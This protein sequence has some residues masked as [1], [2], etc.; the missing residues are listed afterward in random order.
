M[1]TGSH[2]AVPLEALLAESAWLRRLATS[3]VRD[4][5]A[6]EDLVQETWLA[7]LKNPPTADRPLR[8]WLRTV[9]ENFVRMRARGEQ[10]RTTRERREAREEATQGEVEL[11]ERVEEQ[12]FLAREVLKLEEPF[13]STLV[14]RYYEGL[15]SIQ[16]AERVGSNDNTVR[17]R[18]KRGLELLRERLDRRHGGDRGAWLALLSPL[19]PRDFAPVTAP[20]AS[21]GSGVGLWFAGAAAMLAL[22]AGVWFAV[23]EPEHEEQLAALANA[24][25]PAEQP[26]NDGSRA[27]VERNEPASAP[28]PTVLAP[29]R[30]RA[31]VLDVQ[32]EPVSGARGLLELGEAEGPRG[33]SRADGVLEFE[34]SGDSVLASSDV[35]ELSATG[36]EP[37]RVYAPVRPGETLELG[38]LVL[39]RTG[40][41]LGSVRDASG[42]PI[43]AAEVRL[44]RLGERFGALR[45]PPLTEI[46]L[47]GAGLEVSAPVVVESDVDGRFRLQDVAEAYYR[48][49]IRAE[50]FARQCSGPLGV[51]QGATLMLEPFV[52]APP[53]P[54]RLVRGVVLDAHGAPV[55]QARVVG[56]RSS[57]S[58]EFNW[59]EGDVRTTSDAQGRFTLAA[60]PGNHYTIAATDG[61]RFASA[62]TLVGDR[63]ELLLRLQERPSLELAIGSAPIGELEILGVKD[64]ADGPPLTWQV[65]EGVIGVRVEVTREFTL[66]VKHGPFQFE[67]RQ[68]ALDSRD[69]VLPERIDLG[70]PVVKALEVRVVAQGELV[71]G[72]HVELGVSRKGSGWISPAANATTDRTGIAK[73][74][75]CGDAITSVTVRAAGWRPQ[76]LREQPAGDR[77]DVELVRGG[78]LAGTVRDHLGRT[79]RG[80]R[81]SIGSKMDVALTDLDGA[82]RVEGLE[83]GRWSVNVS[84]SYTAKLPNKRRRTLLSAVRTEG[85]VAVLAGH[86]TL[87]DVQ[88][89]EPPQCVLRGRVALDGSADGPRIVELAAPGD[90]RT[91]YRLRTSPR[92]DFEFAVRD[93]GFY[94]LRCDTVANGGVRSELRQRVSLVRGVTLYRLEAPS[95]TLLVK[96]AVAAAPEHEL[97]VVVDTPPDGMWTAIAR[98]DAEGRARV[99]VPSGRCRVAVEGVEHPELALDLRAGE[100]REILWPPR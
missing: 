20:P 36:F 15:S 82:Y 37:R 24:S 10:A 51:Q 54:E 77:I 12:R 21:T 100:T 88:L 63:A 50:G 6:A 91:L 97:S 61:P 49:W 65:A 38:D 85:E 86:V 47:T 39:R 94:Q 46:L 57:V 3:L 59:A 1:D 11:V 96:L 69:L 22:V 4:P 30:I 14:L 56:Q 40:L 58:R 33:L 41:I 32:S 18:L 45:E 87:H 29:A 17:W 2:G 68:P 89:P 48:V 80:A 31:R 64:P 35:L 75:W 98:F 19:T 92:G 66:R 7:A 78:V 8:P 52:L 5:A 90:S 16:I 70:A 44:E 28:A 42:A 34:V 81:I 79:V 99:R 83:P 27:A 55:A 71:A 62:Y 23:R 76:S 67:R 93:P 43:E 53:A 26:T 60:E 95:A 13:R 73:V 74:A 72:A 25:A 84:S 9:L